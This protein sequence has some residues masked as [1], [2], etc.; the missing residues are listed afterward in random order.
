[1]RAPTA[2]VP[3]GELV[4][5]VPE[6]CPNKRG[7]GLPALPLTNPLQLREEHHRAGSDPFQ[8]SQTVLCKPPPH[9][10]LNSQLPQPQPCW[11]K[12]SHLFQWVEGKAVLRVLQDAGWE[13][14]VTD[15]MG[16]LLLCKTE[17]AAR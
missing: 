2:P 16:V 15:L 9:N 10:S 1:M 12:E 3:R 5:G 14:A 11:G 13:T 4:A 7:T 6:P 17:K 8:E